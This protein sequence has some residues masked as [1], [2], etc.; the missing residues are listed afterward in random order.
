MRVP[1]LCWQRQL[2]HIA[3]ES[4]GG[5]ITRRF[6]WWHMLQTCCLKQHMWQAAC[7]LVV[8]AGSMLRFDFAFVKCVHSSPMLGIPH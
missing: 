6:A 1:P 5:S 3:D 2:L 7:P 4:S 8:V